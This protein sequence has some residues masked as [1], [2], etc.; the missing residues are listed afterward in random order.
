[1]YETSSTYLQAELDYRAARISAGR[2]PSAV[3]RRIRRGT[4]TEPRRERALNP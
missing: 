2:S 1:M 3:S 4:P